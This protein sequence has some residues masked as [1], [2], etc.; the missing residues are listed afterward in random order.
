[1]ET[2]ANDADIVDSK[3][4]KETTFS[5]NNFFSKNFMI[6]I[7]IA[8]ILGMVSTFLFGKIE[9][10]D[11]RLRDT[12]I[13]VTKINTAIEG[14]VTLVETEFQNFTK[15]SDLLRKDIDSLETYIRDNN[16]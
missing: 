16:Q 11:E 3:T 14:L 15:R 7:V 12:E 9:G 6:P 4:K 8:L 1:M 13:T 5:H 10:L 2:T